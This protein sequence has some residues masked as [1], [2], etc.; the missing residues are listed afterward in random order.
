MIPRSPMGAERNGHLLLPKALRLLIIGAV[1]QP[2]LPAASPDA[3]YTQKGSDPSFAEVMK[4]GKLPRG[5]NSG[6]GFKGSRIEVNQDLLKGYPSTSRR[7]IED[8]MIH[9]LG[10]SMIR[11]PDF[12][13]WSRWYQEDGNTQIFRLFK[14]EEN[15]RNSRE[16]AA[17]TEAFSAFK[18]KKGDGWQEWVGTYTI[19]KPHGC[20]I[21]QAKNPHN[22][23]SVMINMNDDGDVSLN[24]RRGEDK[25]M[26]R[27]MTAK[28]FQIRIRENGHDYEVYFNGRKE[29]EGSYARTQGET[30]F[31][32]G[33]YLGGREVRHDAMILVTGAAIN[34]R[35]LDEFVVVDPEP[36]AIPEPAPEP[37]P[38]PGVAIPVRKWTNRSDG[39][40][41][42]EAR[43]KPGTDVIHFKIEGTWTAYPL[44]E[45]STEDQREL[46]RAF[47]TVKD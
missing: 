37:E 4:S 27:N 38:P 8:I 5:R 6:N 40:L 15:V 2:G 35:N 21:F 32:W 14:G 13:K 23:W 36:E 45:L 11:R 19:I 41:E 33:M 16:L 26:A 25:V 18:W 3:F 1:L 24:H 31:R 47:E 34:P 30:N 46:V 44:T 17:R 43:Y 28:P 42:A 12:P 9:T 22:D 20:S 7:V 10:N 39:E 29:G